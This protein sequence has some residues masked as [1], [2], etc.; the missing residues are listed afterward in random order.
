MNE[1]DRVLFSHCFKTIK[2]MKK[3]DNSFKQGVKRRDLV[4]MC[5]R[6]IR[7]LQK[8]KEAFQKISFYTNTRKKV[9]AQIVG[10]YGV[11][12]GAT[13]HDYIPLSLYEAVKND[14]S[15]FLKRKEDYFS[16]KGKYYSKRD[17]FEHKGQ[18]VRTDTC[19]K[20]NDEIYPKSDYSKIVFEEWGFDCKD[21]NYKKVKTEFAINISEFEKEPLI[22][23]DAYV[24]ISANT[25]GNDSEELKKMCLACFVINNKRYFCNELVLNMNDFLKMRLEPNEEEKKVGKKFGKTSGV[26]FYARI[27]LL[28]KKRTIFNRV[29]NSKLKQGLITDRNFNSFI[30]DLNDFKKEVE[31]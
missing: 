16:F 25:N 23:T 31:L 11:A 12:Y 14:D 4:Q 7:D 8:N 9:V 17:F 15:T 13:T 3:L 10:M 29:L 2:E 28:D 5:R 22:A 18:L 20:I 24:K 26:M 27:E 30:K 21:G 19:F 1:L 6:T